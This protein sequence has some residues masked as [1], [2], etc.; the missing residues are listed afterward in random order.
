MSVTQVKRKLRRLRVR[1]SKRQ[2]LLKRYSKV[3]TIKQVDVAA[4]KAAFAEQKKATSES[5]A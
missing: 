4:I 5:E 1:A 3:P 2:S